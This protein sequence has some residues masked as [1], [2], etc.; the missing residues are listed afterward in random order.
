MHRADI[1]CLLHELSHPG[2]A[3]LGLGKSYDG[4]G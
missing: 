1:V 4:G 3:E 2:R